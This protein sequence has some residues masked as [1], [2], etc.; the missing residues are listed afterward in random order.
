MPESIGAQDH[1]AV[2]ALKNELEA[3]RRLL[4]TQRDLDEA[5]RRGTNGEDLLRLVRCQEAAARD[6]S[7]A[8][9]VRRMFFS[10]AGSLE[11]YLATGSV[12]PAMAASLREMA[13]EATEIHT[14]LKRL[15]Q[16]SDYVARRSVEWTQAQME[17]VVRWATRS[18]NTYEAPGG[19]APRRE[20]PSWMDRSA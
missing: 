19:V 15:V 2:Q 4:S 10:G 7:L 12:S 20:A 9:G 3:A 16:R 5:L 6:A 8:S 14:T 17:L 18:G 1:G 11:A 13:R